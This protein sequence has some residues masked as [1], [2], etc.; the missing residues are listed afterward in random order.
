[1]DVQKRLAGRD[2]VSRGEIEQNQIEPARGRDEQASR[3][4][5][6]AAV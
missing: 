5:Q 2:R 3:L 4:L 6:Q 1:V